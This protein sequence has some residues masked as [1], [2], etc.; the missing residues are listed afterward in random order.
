MV[1]FISTCLNSSAVEQ[2]AVNRLVVGS[3]PTLG[4]I[5]WPVGET[6]N[7]YAFHAY[8]HGF[9]PRTGHQS[10]RSMRQHLFFS[11]EGLACV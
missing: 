5:L 9:E 10:I 11:K 8:I 2:P 6:V 3:N 7:S 4:A 1:Y